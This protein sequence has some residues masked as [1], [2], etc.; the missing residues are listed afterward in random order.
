MESI[1]KPTVGCVC[2]CV[3]VVV[4]FVFFFLNKQKLRQQLYGG[5]NG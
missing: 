4:F 1:H 3:V 5:K 2:V